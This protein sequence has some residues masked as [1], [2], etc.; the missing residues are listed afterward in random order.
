MLYFIVEKVGKEPKRQT[1]R[2][3]G[4]QNRASVKAERQAAEVE[5]VS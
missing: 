1:H 2:N 3:V 5:G 4:A